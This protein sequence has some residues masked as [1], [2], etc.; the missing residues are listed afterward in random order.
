MENFPLDNLTEILSYFN[1]SD[2]SEFKNI[3]KSFQQAAEE[4]KKYIYNHLLRPD[5][6]VQIVGLQ[7]EKGKVHNGRIG[8]IK[9][10][11][12]SDNDRFPVQILYLTGD[13]ELLAVKATNLNPFLSEHQLE[14]ERKRC[15]AISYTQ[16]GR[17]RESHGMLLDQIFM[18]A[19]WSYNE[20]SGHTYFRNLDF[21]QYM[22]LPRSDPRVGGPNSAVFSFYK[23]KPS[24]AGY[25][26]PH[27]ETIFDAVVKSLVQNQDQLV[28][29][30]GKKTKWPAD[31]PN[32]HL[33]VRNMVRFMS[34]WDREVVIGKFWV[35]KSVKTGTIL[36][37]ENSDESLGK[38]YLVKGLASNIGDL[39]LR[40]GDG[41]TPV[42]GV[43]TIVP[44]YNFL[45][46]DGIALG[47]NQRASPCKK[48]QILN[49]VEDAV[50]SDSI[51]YQ[52]ES[53]S[54]GK[55]DDDEPPI[56]PCIRGDDSL[57]WGQV[58]AI[59]GGA[60]NSNPDENSNALTEQHKHKA[61]EIAKLAKKVGVE[62]RTN[63]K[64]PSSITIRR[65][66]YTKDENP[67]LICVMMLGS[68]PVHTFT[69][70]EWPSY[71]LDEILEELLI[72]LKKIK[73]MPAII[74]VD[75]L[76]LVEPMKLLFDEAF[77]MVAIKES[78]RPKFVWYPPPSAMEQAFNQVNAVHGP[79]P[80]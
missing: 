54:L 67:N 59:Q 35:V 43:L 52:G 10:K 26:I 11:P 8:T 75:E 37:S 25:P 64:G 56:L 61:K 41:T 71:N 15:Q 79:P 9:G 28:Q 62:S 74:M 22:N 33:L 6:Q 12:N 78:K 29:A 42:Q 5:A 68:T 51:L 47:P 58:S 27:D 76:S 77:R 45:V 65:F 14:Q 38:V 2:L 50:K 39:F 53:A 31:G 66:G 48:K 7:S 20:M 17:V 36:V 32:G 24:L 49:H 80:F 40:F 46:Y 23:V 1:L 63:N 34:T 69:F 16:D 19:R 18:L 70:S 57:D 30:V 4:R 13:T 73:K 55:W 3:S 72:C 44:V 60:L 21:F